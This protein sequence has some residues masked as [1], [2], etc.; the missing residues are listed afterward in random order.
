M[1]LGSGTE[2]PLNS[3]ALI[4]EDGRF[5]G[6]EFVRNLSGYSVA[7]LLFQTYSPP[8]VLDRENQ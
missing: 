6:P 3:N 4:G 5:H 1:L 8:V 2:V 7:L